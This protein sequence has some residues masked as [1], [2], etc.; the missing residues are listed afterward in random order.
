[1][2]AGPTFIVRL[3]RRNAASL[4]GVVEHVQTGQRIPF[5]SA[6][7]LWNALLE[8]SRRADQRAAAAPGKRR[9]QRGNKT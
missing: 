1:M 8:R 6:T 5:C 3:Y 2:A 9:A 7:E 4:T